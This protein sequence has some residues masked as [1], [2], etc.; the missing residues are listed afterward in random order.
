MQCKHPSSPANKKFKTQ[1]SAVKVM[2]TIFWDVNDPILM[3]FQEKGQTVTSA[4]YSDILVNELKPA[5]VSKHRGLLSKRVLLPTYGCAYSG[6]T[7]CSEIWGVETSTIQSGLGAIGLSLVWTYKEHLRGQ[8]F[9]DD[10]VMEAMQSWL[11]AMPKSFFSRGLP[12]SLWTHGQS[13]LRSRGTMSKNKTQ[14]I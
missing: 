4:R 5:I 7:M 13:V 2:L 1:A 9:A 11:E 3:H 6:Y 14:F 10:E 8:K 12:Q